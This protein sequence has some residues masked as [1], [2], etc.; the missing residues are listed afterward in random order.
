MGSFGHEALCRLDSL[1]FSVSNPYDI[2]VTLFAGPDVPIETEG[3]EQLLSFLDLQKTLDDLWAREQKGLILPFFGEASGQLERVVLTPDFHRGSGIPVGTVALARGFVIPAA[4]GNDVCC[5]MRLLATDLRADE[6]EQHAPALARRLRE[7]F[8]EGQRDIP[9]SPRQREALLRNGL[10]GL[11]ETSADNADRGLWAYY[12]PGEQ[13]DDLLRADHHGSLPAESIFGF[14]KFVRSSGAIDGRDPQIGSVGG[15]NHFVELGRVD[16]LYEAT[17][18]EW[19]LRKGAVTV[20]VHTGSVGLGH[21]VGGH[22]CDLARREFAA[23]VPHPDHGFFPLP[24]WGPKAGAAGAYLD[25]LKNAANFAFGNR[26]LLGLMAVRAMSEVVGRRV[27]SRLVYDAP[28]NLVWAREGG[29]YLHR[30]G[31]TPAEGPER[32]GGPFASTGRPVL[33]PGSMGASSYVLAGHG[34]VAAL[35]SACH[36]A[37][38]ALDRRTSALIDEATYRR[39]LAPLRVV[40]PLDPDSPSVRGRA[41]VL[42]KYHRRVKE[43]APYAYKD[44]GPVIRTV[45]EAGVARRVARLWP[46]MTVKG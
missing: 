27:S 40:T 8:F 22:F 36:G 13:G 35:E 29:R 16:E 45:E 2:P 34:E 3:I 30:K 24:A 19:G 37:G 6:V 15:G 4:V 43:E 7:L 28:H 18:A 11:W 39:A 12:D 32:L 10:Y 17:A 38:R 46:L 21:A 9:M 20:M 42:A 26:L 31:A 5:G 33:V 44:V 41:D 25:A 14:E 23:G 1:R